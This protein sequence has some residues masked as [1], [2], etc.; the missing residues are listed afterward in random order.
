MVSV[1]DPHARGVRVF[2][3]FVFVLAAVYV[4]R[5]FW[6]MADY[7]APGGPFRYLTLWALL[8]SFVSAGLML[9]VS[10]RRSQRNWGTWVAVTAVTNGLVV[11]LYWRL[12]FADPALVNS[13]GPIVWYVEYYL[14]LSGPLLQWIDA[15]VIFGMFRRF[16]PAFTGLA[17]V[18]V[19]YVAWIELFVGPFNSRPEG[20]VTTGLPYPFLN[21]M[22]WDE[23]LGFYVTTAVSALI[24][25]VIFWALS[26]ASRRVF[27]RKT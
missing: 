11:M 21:S 5:Q 26:W 2:R 18:V 10:E 1:A 13:G 15:L 4:L 6:F 25:L 27:G 12:W 22:V 3:W 24:F 9:A 7:S 16:L 23:R 17:G 14:H 8:L 20:S 19:G